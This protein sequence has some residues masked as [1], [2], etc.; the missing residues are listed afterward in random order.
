MAGRSSLAA[1]L[2]L[3]LC[4]CAG[5]APQPIEVTDGVKY[6]ADLVA[7]SAAAAA[8]KPKLDL[9]SV[10][11]GAGT[12]AAQNVVGAAVNPVVPV[13]GAAGGAGSALVTGLDVMGHARANVARH[14]LIDKLAIDHSAIVARPED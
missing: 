14:C 8:Y 2:P 7:C 4:A 13:I 10:A 3:A 9:G 6:Q 11:A 5:Y 12:G 1:L